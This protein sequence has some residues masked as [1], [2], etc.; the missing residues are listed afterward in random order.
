VAEAAAYHGAP[1][2]AITDA[3]T[4]PAEPLADTATVL[5]APAGDVEPFA[6]LVARY[7]IELETGVDPGEAFRRARAATGWERHA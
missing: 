3:R 6:R 2:V 1:V 4:Q 5:E 7:A